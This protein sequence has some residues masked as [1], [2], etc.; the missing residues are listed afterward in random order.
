MS[1]LILSA[2]IF[3]LGLVSSGRGNVDTIY[4][5]D[6]VGFKFCRNATGPCPTVAKE[7]ISVG[8]TIRWINVSGL[9]SHTTTSD[10]GVTPSWDSGTMPV[11]SSFS[12]AFTQAGVFPYHCVPHI[13]NNQRDTI[14]VQPACVAKAGDANADGNI[15]LSDVI[16]VINFLFKS[17]GLSPVC[18]GN[19]N[20]DGSVLLSDV[21]Y[22]VNFLFKSGAAPVKNNECCL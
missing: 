21:V 15:L 20:G 19:V 17:G 11:G 18:R 4:I 1:K 14:Y 2:L 13:I 10:S 12:F 9:T 6:D 8:D 3:V 7:T 16:V 5:R 22:L